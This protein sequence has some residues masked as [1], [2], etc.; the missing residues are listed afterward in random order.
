MLFAQMKRP[1]KGDWYLVV[2]EDL[3]SLGLGHLTL[4]DIASK[5]KYSMKKIVKEASEKTA[6]QYLMDKKQGLSKLKDLKYDKLKF[7]PYLA[8]HQMNNRE[9]N[10]AFSLRTRMA[11]LPSNYGVKTHCKLCQD[12]TTEDNQLHLL[13]QCTTLQQACPELQ[14][15]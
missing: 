9:K 5:T 8:C 2:K 4:E 14:T 1:V 7:Q 13:Q 3:E 11:N 15:M 12:P 6:L 10:L